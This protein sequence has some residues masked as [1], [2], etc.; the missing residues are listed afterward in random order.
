M[1]LNI[2]DMMNY[3]FYTLNNIFW[4]FMEGIGMHGNYLSSQNR[5]SKTNTLPTHH[6][7]ITYITV[8]SE[9]IP[10][11]PKE[12]AT[13]ESL[14]HKNNPTA[15]QQK[16]ITPPPTPPLSV[17]SSKPKKADTAE[18][19]PKKNN[20]AATQQKKTTP[21][22]ADTK[23]IPSKPKKADT[24]ESL[25]KKNNPTATQQKK[26]TPPPVISS[27]PKKADTAE[28][29]PKKNNSTAAQQKKTTPPAAD[30]K[31]IPSKPKKPATPESLPHKNNSTAA[32]QKKTTPPANTKTIPSKPKK[33]ATPESLPHKNNPTAAQ[34]KKTPPPPPPPPVISSKPKKADTAESLPKKNNPT[35]TQQ[36]KTTPPANTK[37][38]TDTIKKD[39][40]SLIAQ[41]QCSE[42]YDDGQAYYMASR[43]N[44]T[45]FVRYID[46]PYTKLLAVPISTRIIHRLPF[47]TEPIITIP[48]SIYKNS[49]RDDAPKESIKYAFCARAYLL[50][51]NRNYTADLYID[52]SMHIDNLP[53]CPNVATS[54]NTIKSIGYPFKTYNRSLANKNYFLISEKSYGIFFTRGNYFTAYTKKPL[55]IGQ[56]LNK[57]H[58]WISQLFFNNTVIVIHNNMCKIFDSQN[59]QYETKEDDKY[60]KLQSKISYYYINVSNDYIIDYFLSSIKIRYINNETYIEEWIKVSTAP[61]SNVIILPYF[62][63]HDHSFIEDHTNRKD[64]VD[65]QETCYL[66]IEESILCITSSSAMKCDT[67]NLAC[68]TQC[69]TKDSS[70]T[71]PTLYLTNLSQIEAIF[72]LNDNTKNTKISY[73]IDKALL[74]KDGYIQAE[75]HSIL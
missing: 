54:Q 33:P 24:A 10:S 75:S 36:K 35:A 70:V 3:F 45:F 65:I 69:I 6:K 39:N 21:P 5:R 11:K 66:K 18:S 47:K 37:T 9:A 52:L 48:I 55:I 68:F 63:Y 67:S 31:T 62:Y 44:N 14:P 59:Y 17:I 28:S 2:V 71:S 43:G 53:S 46:N 20:P 49:Y 32:Q 1:R 4:N 19:L 8:T 42:S 40:S 57:K 27:K 64:Y 7:K 15:A 12:S 23:T 26:T 29:L 50:E 60:I 38:T 73:T 22:A 41:Q 25:P 74:S 13:P 56:M 72:D 30:T 34:Q 16:K 58:F 51:D 61:S